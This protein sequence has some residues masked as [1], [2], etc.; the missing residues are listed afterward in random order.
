MKNYT[1]DFVFVK[2]FSGE[3][4]FFCHIGSGESAQL[5]SQQCDFNNDLPFFRMFE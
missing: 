3:C 1:P 5:H 4:K 2:S